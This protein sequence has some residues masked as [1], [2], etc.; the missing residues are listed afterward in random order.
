[1]SDSKIESNHQFLPK[2]HSKSIVHLK[3]GI[4]TAL[5]ESIFIAAP[6]LIFFPFPPYLHVVQPQPRINPRVK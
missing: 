5:L 1:M 2:N 6:W 3:P 4:V